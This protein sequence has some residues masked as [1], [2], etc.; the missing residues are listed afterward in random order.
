MDLEED[1]DEVVNL[2][3]RPEQRERVERFCAQLK[4][5]QQQTGDPWLHKWVYE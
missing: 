4:A 1:P 5:F 3:E 2:A